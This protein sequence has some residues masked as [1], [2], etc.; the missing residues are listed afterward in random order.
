MYVQQ[1]RQFSA[2]RTTP[3]F[4]GENDKIAELT[5]LARNFQIITVD[6]GWFQNSVSRILKH[7]RYYSYK[8]S[9]HHGVNS[10]NSFV[11]FFN[12]PP[13]PNHDVVNRRS[14]HLRT[15]HNSYGFVKTRFGELTICVIYRAAVV[16]GLQLL[17][18]HDVFDAC[19]VSTLAIH[20]LGGK[21]RHDALTTC[22]KSFT[23][24]RAKSLNERLRK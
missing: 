5:V 18:R 2:K 24:G 12:E 20:T 23:A 8:V 16:R 6:S 9:W 21:V 4:T 17:S 11:W 3:T 15:A 13:L 1:W 22:S 7:Q 19:D 10:Q 14:A